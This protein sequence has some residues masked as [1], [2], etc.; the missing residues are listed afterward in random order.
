MKNALVLVL[1]IALVVLGLLFYKRTHG[2]V[3]KARATHQRTD[4][5]GKPVNTEECETLVGKNN[6]VCIIPISYL[7]SMTTGGR[8]DTNALEVHHKDT[9]VWYGDHGES[10]E[11]QQMTGADCSKH[12]PGDPPDNPPYGSDPLLVD[13]T[14][15]SPNLTYAHITDNPKNDRY[16]YKTNINVTTLDGKKIPIDPHTFDQ[17]TQ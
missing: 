12:A 8:P 6:D 13:I 3:G 16:C 5:N 10:I 1:V 15:V 17:P 2:F 4:H 9:I 14:P 7:L 11:V